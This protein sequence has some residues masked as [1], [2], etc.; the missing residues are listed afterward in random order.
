VASVREQVFAPTLAGMAKEGRSYRG[1]LYAGLM[2]TA[3]GPRVL[4]FNCRFGD[5]ETQVVLP[6]LDTDLVEV[7]EAI[8]DGRLDRTPIRWREQTAVCVVMTAKGYPG[9]YHRGD[10]ISGLDAGT[11]DSV[12]FHAGTA[13][14]GDRL[15]TSGGR[16]LG[17]TGLA[18]TLAQAR[19][20]AYTR[21]R[22]ISFAGASYRSDIAMRALSGLGSG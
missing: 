18:G 13:R 3:T 4:E 2:L 8:V 17:V 12:V 7:S 16:V 6:L 22:A 19:D 20:R 15:V 9:D 5:P 10:A 11:A 21:V 14:D 1:I